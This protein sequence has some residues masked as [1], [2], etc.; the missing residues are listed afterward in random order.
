MPT[1]E[2]LEL[3]ELNR[4]QSRGPGGGPRR[5]AGARE[6]CLRDQQGSIRSN[7]TAR[8]PVEASTGREAPAV[9]AWIEDYADEELVEAEIAFYV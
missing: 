6:A 1:K 3:V 5:G 2:T 9:V 4:A 8:G 7:A